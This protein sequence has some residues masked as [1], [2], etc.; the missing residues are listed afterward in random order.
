MILRS[1]K[2]ADGSNKQRASQF[3][4]LIPPCLEEIDNKA[5]YSLALLLLANKDDLIIPID[6]FKHQSLV[7]G[8]EMSEDTAVES[9]MNQIKNLIFQNLGQPVPYDPMLYD[10]QAIDLMVNS[11]KL[12][13]NLNIAL[14]RLILIT[15]RN[16]HSTPRFVKHLKSKREERL[17]VFHLH[18]H[19]AL[20][21]RYRNL[22][23][24]EPMQLLASRQLLE[25]SCSKGE[26]IV[27]PLP[28]LR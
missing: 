11:H 3:C 17:W 5:E 18:H 2:G 1:C 14:L 12:E 24:P 25:E 23:K 26:E 8:K 7:E 15:S 20:F 6:T 22:Q 10:G 13:I 19:R 4:A 28:K 16:F 21:L 27:L 9:T